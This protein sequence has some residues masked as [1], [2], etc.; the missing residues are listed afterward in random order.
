MTMIGKGRPVEV[1]GQE[2]DWLN[3]KAGNE[4]GWIHKT[5]IALDKEKPNAASLEDRGTSK[6]NAGDISPV[7]L[8]TV[9]V[10]SPVLTKVVPLQIA[11]G[12]R[13]EK[14]ENKDIPGAS[15]ERSEDL[16]HVYKLAQ[17]NDPTFS[18]RWRTVRNP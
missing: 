2:G 10:E 7:Q 4:E 9:D 15:T 6:S 5:L 13:N 11:E 14:P 18:R 3:V 17:E 1:F 12:N 8:P 16:I